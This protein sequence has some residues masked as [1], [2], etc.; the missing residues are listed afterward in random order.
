MDS[1]LMGLQWANQVAVLLGSVAL[2]RLMGRSING[3]EKTV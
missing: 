2:R 3:N 1:L